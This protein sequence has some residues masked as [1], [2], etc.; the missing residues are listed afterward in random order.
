VAREWAVDA[1]DVLWRRTKLGP[2]F[3]DREVEDLEAWLREI[4]TRHVAP[5][6]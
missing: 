4:T 6:A 1:E 3:S 5:A 2:R